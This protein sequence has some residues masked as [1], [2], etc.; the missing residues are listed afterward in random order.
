MKSKVVIAAAIA[1]WTAML[2]V[3]V[4]AADMNGRT[5]EIIESEVIRNA[6]T[7]S[8]GDTIPI[9]GVGGG[10]IHLRTKMSASDPAQECDSCS[11]PCRSFTGDVVDT[12]GSGSFYGDVCRDPTGGDWRIGS[13]V[14][15]RWTLSSNPPPLPV[16]PRPLPVRPPPP[17]PPPPVPSP[18]LLSGIESN[19]AMLRYLDDANAPPKSVKAAI[20]AFASDAQIDE[21][22][23]TQASWLHFND[24][25]AKAVERGKQ[26]SCDIPAALRHNYMMCSTLGG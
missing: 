15:E 14:T 26:A 1:I 5:R 7:A 17:P 2:A 10:S 9:V 3:S 19:L 4:A 20:A 25:L 16:A 23:D 13:L 8:A 24:A 11:D 6:E 21:P 12:T 18:E 22:S